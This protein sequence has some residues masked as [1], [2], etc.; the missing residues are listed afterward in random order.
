MWTTR[1]PVATR[2]AGS[3]RPRGRRTLPAPVVGRSAGGRERTPADTCLLVASLPSP[4]SR[5]APVAS[6]AGVGAWS[7]RSPL[8]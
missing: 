5:D 3:G 1:T 7:V 8:A 2:A 6:F 4:V